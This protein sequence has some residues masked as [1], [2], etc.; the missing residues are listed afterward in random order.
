MGLK[1]AA[2]AVLCI[3]SSAWGSDYVITRDNDSAQMTRNMESSLTD[4]PQRKILR[5][6]IFLLTPEYYRERGQLCPPCC[7]AD[8]LTCMVC[9]V[10]YGLSNM[11][12]AHIYHG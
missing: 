2:A 1:C 11:C 9:R 10:R 3:C 7:I 5:K 6:M 4:W 12:S 8:G